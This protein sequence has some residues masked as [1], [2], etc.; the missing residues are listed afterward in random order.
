[1]EQIQLS[2]KELHSL[3]L[4]AYY[5]KSHG[6]KEARCDLYFYEDGYHIETYDLKYWGCKG[7]GTSFESYESIQ[8]ILQKVI[9][10]I[11]VSDYLEGGGD[12][13]R[14]SIVLSIDADERKLEVR[15]YE[16]VQGTNDLGTSQEFNEPKDEEDYPDIVAF[17][18]M[19]EEKG[20]KQGE[21]EFNGGGDSGEIYDRMNVS[22][23]DEIRLNKEVED[24]LYSFLG[25]FYGGWEINEGSHGYFTFYTKTKEIVLSFYEHTETTE[26]RG[27]ILHIDF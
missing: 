23:H 3:K 22:G 10:N 19:L 9:D 14:G 5:V 24:F 11:Q 25:D 18:K 4:F 27:K 1:M 21:V 13:S 17:F 12:E 20:I 8:E 6:C 15:I 26:D 2:D 7:G 16:T